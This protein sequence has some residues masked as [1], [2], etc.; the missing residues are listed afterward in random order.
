MVVMTSHVVHALLL[1]PSDGKVFHVG[2]TISD[3]DCG[4][5]E[6]KF[7]LGLERTLKAMSVFAAGC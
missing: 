2:H 3:V 5:S 6:F 4:A 1:P 7:R